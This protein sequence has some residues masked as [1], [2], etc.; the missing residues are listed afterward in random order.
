[1]K[2]GQPLTFAITG[3]EASDFGPVK[4]GLDLALPGSSFAL[5]NYIGARAN[6]TATGN[7]KGYPVTYGSRCNGGKPDGPD[8]VRGCS[9]SGAGGGLHVCCARQRDETDASREIRAGQKD[10]RA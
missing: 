3:T 10:C 2:Q 1:M 5:A 7:S 9:Q 8:V 6:L 4:L